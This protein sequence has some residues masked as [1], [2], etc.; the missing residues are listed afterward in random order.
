MQK[1]KMKFAFDCTHTHTP[2]GEGEELQSGK[3]ELKFIIRHNIIWSIYN[4]SAVECHVQL[5]KEWG[6]RRG[7]VWAP[8]EAMSD[9]YAHNKRSH[10]VGKF[11]MKS[12]RGQNKK[13]EEEEETEVKINKK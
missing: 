13:N 2:S 11:S 9:S 5:F 12:T 8:A 6:W 4:Y 7:G 10:K 1:H 3:A